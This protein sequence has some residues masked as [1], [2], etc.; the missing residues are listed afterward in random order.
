MEGGGIH[1]LT[2]SLQLTT[3]RE[4]VKNWKR[5]QKKCELGLSERERE[6]KNFGERIYQ[7]HGLSW[8]I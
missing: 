5:R 3:S 1:L 4:K 6:N 7:F 2:N 8:Y